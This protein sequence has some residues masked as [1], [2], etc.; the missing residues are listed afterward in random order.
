MT[1]FFSEALGLTPSAFTLLRDLI[2]DRTGIYFDEGKQDILADKLS[3]RVIEA[4]F[5][6]FLDYYYLLKYDTAGAEEWGRLMNTITVQETYFWRELDQIRALVDVILPEYTEAHPGRPIR[7]WSAV[8]AT[9]EEPISMAMALEEGGWFQRRPVAI[10]ASDASAAALEKARQGVYR[11]RSFRNLPPQLRAR[12]FEE[13]P[14]GHRVSPMLHDKIQWRRANLM[15][16]D[17][18]RSM[19]ES[20]FI[21]CRN[22]FIYFS[23]E[24]TKRT[25]EL[26][27]RYMPTPGFL[28]TGASES[29]LTITRDF[30]LEEIGG[31]FVYVKR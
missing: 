18:I 13:E 19:A 22:V 24:S 26:F 9:G 2:H 16:E 3:P 15:V 7:I 17:E 10:H 30:E 11:G 1:H 6:S 5:D 14:G 12:Y 20:P 25:V 27:H 8:C 4:G 29:L 21:F 31:A 28:F 23:K